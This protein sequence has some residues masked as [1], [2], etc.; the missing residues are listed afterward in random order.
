[1]DA[2]QALLP[3]RLSDTE[4]TTAR[5]PPSQA[6]ELAQGTCIVAGIGD[7]YLEEA[8]GSPT[9]RVSDRASEDVVEHA[10]SNHREGEFAI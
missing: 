2:P 9:S 8:D 7:L 5:A 6:R 1:L 3:H 10:K 4:K